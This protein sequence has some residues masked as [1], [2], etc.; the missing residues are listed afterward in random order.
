MISEEKRMIKCRNC[1]RENDDSFTFC[2]DCGQRLK[3]EPAKTVEP[4]PAGQ[5]VSPSPAG[6]ASVPVKS[7]ASVVKQP[8]TPSTKPA[9]TKK[10]PSCGKSVGATDLFCASCGFKLG[11]PAVERRTMFLHSTGTGETARPSARLIL[12]M[13]DGSEGTVF[14]LKEGVS[15]IGRNQG[16]IQFPADPYLSPRHAQITV[17][18]KKVTIEDLGSLNGVYLRMR[19]PMPLEPGA[20]FRIGQQLLRLELPGDFQPLPI[21]KAPDDDSLFWGSPPPVVWARLV[22]ILEGGKIGEIHL[23]SQPEV[24]IGRETGDICFPEDNFVSAKHC[25]LQNNDG[26]V[27]LRDLGSS[28]GTF[29]RLQGAQ[30]ITSDDR[31]QIGGQVL[32]LEIL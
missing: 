18:S 29:L 11:Q 20:S 25:A 21:K 3:P 7:P 32:R 6:A 1:G 30:K 17:D 12:I 2:L 24:I 22:Q 28:N 4:Q 8:A 27:M 13:P 15:L 9:D 16:E 10:C 19:Q 14:S 5:A 31:L 23:L 26:V